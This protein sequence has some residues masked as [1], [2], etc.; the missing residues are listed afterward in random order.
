MTQ[1]T[2]FSLIF[3]RTT[4]KPGSTNLNNLAEL[5]GDTLTLYGNQS[6]EA[7]DRNWGI[8]AAGA[9]TQIVFKFIDFDEVCRHL[10]KIRTRFPATQV[11]WII[12]N[13]L[14]CLLNGSLV[15]ELEDLLGVNPGGFKVDC[16]FLSSPEPKANR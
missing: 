5:E 3:F 7:L 15:A 10:H 16:L 13:N 11:C 6:M 14:N 9:V 4:D 1:L 8:Q 12:Q 2:F